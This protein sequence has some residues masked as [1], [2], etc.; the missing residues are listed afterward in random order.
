MIKYKCDECGSSLSIKDELAGTAGKCPKCNT[1]FRVPEP[2]GG[3]AEPSSEKKKKKSKPVEKEPTE[4]EMIFGEDFFKS[5]DAPRRP[6]P[7]APVFE[8]EKEAKPKKPKK[9]F[10]AAKPTG[11]NSANIAGDLLAKMGKKNR[12]SDFVEEEEGEGGYDLSAI[13]YLIIWRVLPVVIGLGVLIPLF[14][15]F[16][17]GILVGG[18]EIPPLAE[19]SGMVTVDGEPAANAELRF[20]PFQDEDHPTSRGLSRAVTGADGSYKP[21]YKR[22]IPGV[23]LGKHNVR[24]RVGGRMIEH[25][26]TVAE[27]ET[28]KNIELFTSN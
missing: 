25:E 17:S 3:S 4:E 24:V 12:P 19:I 22:D 6:Q 9:P 10:G 20:V 28:E 8:E 7:V 14:Y 15:W 27:G 2:T 21:F 1:K 5:D 26:I 23:V 16:F 18:V 13:N 11:D